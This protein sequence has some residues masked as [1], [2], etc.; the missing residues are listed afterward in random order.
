MPSMPLCVC[1]CVRARSLCVRHCVFTV[2]VCV[3]TKNTKSV[4]PQEDIEDEGCHIN[5]ISLVGSVCR[6]YNQHAALHAANPFSLSALHTPPHQLHHRNHNA[7]RPYGGAKISSSEAKSGLPVTKVCCK[8]R[9]R[10]TSECVCVEGVA[11]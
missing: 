5:F 3:S 6:V 1:V 8:K 10:E 2:C 11:D 9:K 4:C 7:P